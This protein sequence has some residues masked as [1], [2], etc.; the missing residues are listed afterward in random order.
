MKGNSKNTIKELSEKINS[1]IPGA[2][3]DGQL[4]IE[5]LNNILGTTSLNFSER[6]QLNWP[7]KSEAYK[8]LQKPTF[9]T[10]IPEIKTSVNWDVSNHVFIEGEN[11]EV[12]KVLQKSYFGK[13]KMI[14]IDPPYNTGSDSFIYGDN[15]SE[16]KADYLKKI[17]GSSL[18]GSTEKIKTNRKEGGHFHSNWLNMMLPRLFLARN[19]LT[20]DGVIFVS[21]DDNEAANLKLLLDEVFGETNFVCQFIWRKKAGGG[22]DSEDVAV[23]HEYI[24]CYKKLLNGIFKIPLDKKTLE[25]YKNID[26]KVETHGKYALKELN[27][28]SLSDSPGLH[29]DIECPDGS[30]LKAN[31][32]QWKCNKE[33]FITRKND[34]RIIFKKDKLK[35][36]VYYKIYLNEEKSI[37]RKDDNGIIIPRGKNATSILYDIALN[38]SGNDD[39]KKLFGEKPFD[40]PKPVRL[41]RHLISMATRSKNNDLVMDFFC[42]SG[43]LAQAVLEMNEEDGGNRKFL[44]VQL[45]EDITNSKKNIAPEKY[46]TIADITRDRIY[47][48]LSKTY[49]KSA[50][51]R[52]FR[53]SKSNFPNW[54]SDPIKEKKDLIDQIKNFTTPVKLAS[55]EVLLWEILIKHGTELTEKPEIT[56]ENF[57]WLEKEKTAIFVSFISENAISEAIRKIVR[58]VIILEQ[59]YKGNEA[60]KANIE[61]ALKQNNIIFKNY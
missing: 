12:L 44:C 18:N 34:N 26:E 27:D 57:Y 59:L 9:S 55:E 36:K 61:Q 43:T 19:L 29:Y 49:K 25:K 24:L 53:L 23:E 30:I 11:F 52:H 33:T 1:L 3:K 16:K 32:H 10:L 13:V 38:K 20:E 60:L 41:I 8:E 35:W 37:L 31:E 5:L 21:I 22:N 4:D 7:G 6:Y 50:G 40:Y 42:G 39:I 28:P 17:N 56:H 54:E 47:K 45:P 14:Y 58:T 2:I 46:K 51:F 15:F 48:V